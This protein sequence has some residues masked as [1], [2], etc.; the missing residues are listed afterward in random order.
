M[1]GRALGVLGH[2]NSYYEFSYTFQMLLQLD[3][4]HRERRTITLGKSML[5]PPRVDD[6]FG[7]PNVVRPY[8][9]SEKSMGMNIIHKWISLFMVINLFK[10]IVMHNICMVTF[11]EIAYG[12][13]ALLAYV[14]KTTV[15]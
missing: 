12:E 4:D 2:P 1:H 5:K 6:T 7:S 15:D 13:I 14:W 9:I 8:Q 3:F 10:L 11:M